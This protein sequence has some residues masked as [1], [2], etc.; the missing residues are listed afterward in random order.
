[1][2][3]ATGNEASDF[4]GPFSLGRPMTDDRYLIRLALPDRPGGLALVTRC[5]ANC[6]TDILAV[7]VVGHRNGQAIDDLLVHGGDL[8]RA[9]NALEPEV[10]LLGK[11]R[12]LDLPDPGIAMA[13]AFGRTIRASDPSTARE[14]LLA[15]LLAMVSADAGVL[16]AAPDRQ[17]LTPI[18]AI[19][20]H[21]PPIAPDEPCIA[22]RA[23]RTGEPVIAAAEGSWAPLSYRQ[24]IDAR[25][26]A[27]A[28]ISA[29]PGTDLVLMLARNDVFPFVDAEVERAC[30]L[31]TAAGEGLLGRATA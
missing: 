10:S 9:L 2:P 27:A 18:A 13:E 19:P 16:F 14:A 6:G 1:M 23:L 20:G 21:L 29:G 12:A 8:Q 26:L 31:V 22:R 4:P 17:R 25:E 15:S 3:I 28:P 7:A 5:L 30:A 24:A 11:R